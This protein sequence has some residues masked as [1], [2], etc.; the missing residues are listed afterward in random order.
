MPRLLLSNYYKLLSEIIMDKTKIRV[1]TLRY[2]IATSSILLRTR[3]PMH[4]RLVRA[5]EIRLIV[6]TRAEE[7]SQLLMHFHLEGVERIGL[8]VNR[9]ISFV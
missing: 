4:L 7:S 1:N 5:A 6:T 9:K 8:S 3:S 2:D